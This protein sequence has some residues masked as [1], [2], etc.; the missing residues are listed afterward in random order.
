MRKMIRLIVILIIAVSVVGC[1]AATDEPDFR[2][3]VTGELQPW[4]HEQFDADDDKFTFAIFSDLTGGE[5]ERIF[6]IAVAQL[7]LLR[8]ELIINVGDLIEGG[9]EDLD[10]IAAQWD[11]FDQRA[12]KARAPVFYVG[13]NHDLS[14]AFL[15]G[16]IQNIRV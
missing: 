5:R 3:E 4:T 10:E 12:E 7:N 6:E 1:T 14:G 2:H 8:P 15:Q 11:W 16:A 9:S 13:G